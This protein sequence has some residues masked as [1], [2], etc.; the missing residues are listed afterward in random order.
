MSLQY[1]FVNGAFRYWNDTV[2]LPTK[3]RKAD[4]SPVYFVRK[5]DYTEVPSYW[6][7]E[8][9]GDCYE[10]SRYYN[11]NNNKITVATNLHCTPDAILYQIADK[12]WRAP[13]EREHT[14]VIGERIQHDKYPVH[15]SKELDGKSIMILLQVYPKMSPKEIM[16]VLE[17]EGATVDAQGIIHKAER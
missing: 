8:K 14:T 2:A 6:M 11:T 5:Q 15:W 9:V 4:G 7:Y 17:N 13:Q 10:L 1:K 12:M 16:M 3:R